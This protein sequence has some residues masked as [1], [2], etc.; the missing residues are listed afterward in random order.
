CVEDCAERLR[1]A[2]GVTR[3]GNQ[4]D[5]PDRARYAI[6]L[7]GD[8][9]RGACAECDRVLRSLARKAT[10]LFRSIATAFAACVV[11]LSSLSVASQAQRGPSTPEERKQAL[12][13]IHSW[14]SDP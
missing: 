13:K 12:E 8:E 11:L 9:P 1:G 3:P 14:Q 6:A 5:V 10:M 2:Q 7:Q 4:D